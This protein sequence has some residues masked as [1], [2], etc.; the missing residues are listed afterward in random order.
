MLVA[1]VVIAVAFPALLGLHNR[2]L[3]LVGNDQNLSTATLLMRQ[4]VAQVE[5]QTEF[6]DYG[7]VSGNFD[8]YP[9]FRYELEISHTS[10]DELRQVRLR[11]LWDE[12]HHADLLYYV[13][14]EPES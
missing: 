3:V 12:R 14:R 4:L 8:G 10:F 13:H 9:G 6:S 11:V 7:N 2:N 5:L 1:I